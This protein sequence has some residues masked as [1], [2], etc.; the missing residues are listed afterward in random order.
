MTRNII[1]TGIKD[2]DN[3]ILCY[4]YEMEKYIII[5]ILS[6]ILNCIKKNKNDG[7]PM[8]DVDDLNLD[9]YK[10]I[11]HNYIYNNYNYAY[12]YY[13]NN[14]Y[15]IYITYDILIQINKLILNNLYYY[16]ENNNKDKYSLS[17]RKKN[18]SLFKNGKI[19]NDNDYY[20]YILKKSMILAKK[21]TIYY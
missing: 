17:R 9:C 5:N 20:Y 16:L 13:K 4:K 15:K 6:N 10:N 14:T 8:F 2:I 7:Y 11:V 21:S 19:I 18:C 1:I 12:T 3:I